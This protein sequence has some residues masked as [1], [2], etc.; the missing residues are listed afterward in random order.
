MSLNKILYFL[1]L[2]LYILQANAQ[3]DNHLHLQGESG[4]IVY[5]VRPI[6][7]GTQKL[8]HGKDAKEYGYRIPS[9][10][11]TQKGT[12]LAFAER[13]LGLHDHAQND[14]VVKRS[15]DGGSTWTE[16]MV[17]H[18]DG[19]NSINDPLTVQLTNGRILLMFARF[20]YGRHARNSGWIKMAEFGYDDPKLH[21]LTYVMHSDD[22]GLTW[23]APKDITRMV[24]P[25]HWL[26]AN[27]PGA[28]IQ[29][30]NGEHK[31]RILAS[32]WGTTPVFK[33]DKVFREWEIQ[34]VWSDD[35]GTTWHRSDPLKDPETGF[36]NE[37]QIA[38]CSN[39]EL[40]IIARNQSGKPKR[41]KSFSEDAGETWSVVET[42]STLPSVACMGALIKGPVNKDGSWDLFA[43]FPS[44]EGRINGQIAVSNNNGQSFEIKSIIE[45]DFAYSVIQV[46]PDGKDL[47]VL[48]ETD[49]YKT[50]RFLRI[51]LE[52]LNQ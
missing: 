10:L 1:C 36:T 29:L 8:G 49:Q 12:L 48:Y 44:A 30:Q 11:V 2:T 40:L 26:N 3:D 5:S 28:M 46:S 6:P 24:K 13:R 16:E 14:I 45:G 4:K 38:E 18:E 42:D 20:P 31:G 35:L 15:N 39:G 25:K 19:M 33:G 32:L 21:I 22:D 23:S 41:K 17:V 52:N 51:P 50:I 43:S 47:Y 34:S 7:E 37:C 9:L 27:T